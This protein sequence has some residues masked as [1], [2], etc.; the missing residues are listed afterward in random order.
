MQIK[1]L[2][3]K[4]GAN[5]V[6]LQN[7]LD[8]KGWQSSLPTALPDSVLLSLAMDFRRIEADFAPNSMPTEEDG[9][10]LAAAIYLVM[11]L[12]AEHPGRHVQGDELQLSEDSLMRAIQVY[13]IGLERE[14]VTRITGLAPLTGAEALTDE[15]IRC[16]DD[17]L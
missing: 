3:P 2:R 4:Q 7:L 14:I 5:L 12:L 16:A 9:S 6:H 17:R 15:L 1:A 8:G 11:N 10:S 13:Q